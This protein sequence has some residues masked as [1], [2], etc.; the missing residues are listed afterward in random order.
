MALM[1]LDNPKSYV[2]VKLL[3]ELKPLEMKEYT[4]WSEAKK[5]SQAKQS[6]ASESEAAGCVWFLYLIPSVLLQPCPNGVEVE[7]V[8]KLKS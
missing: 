8:L 5:A 2:T 3:A 4:S 7:Q 1:R 6:M